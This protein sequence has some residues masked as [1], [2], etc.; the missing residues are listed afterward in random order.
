MAIAARKAIA[1]IRKNLRNTVL[2]I[3]REEL[4]GYTPAH[5]AETLAD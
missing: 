3:V 4:T 2:V 1:P 5:A